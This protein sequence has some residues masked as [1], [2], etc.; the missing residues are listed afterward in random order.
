LLSFITLAEVE[1][2]WKELQTNE[3]STEMERLLTGIEYYISEQNS[4]NTIEV[5]ARKFEYSFL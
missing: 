1:N 5:T 4:N 3:L 2:R